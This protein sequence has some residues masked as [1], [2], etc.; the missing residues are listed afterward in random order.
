[1]AGGVVA[2]AYNIADKTDGEVPTGTRFQASQFENIDRDIPFIPIRQSVRITNTTEVMQRG[3][4]VRFLR[5]NNL[6]TKFRSYVDAAQTDATHPNR[7]K[8][9]DV[10]E[11]MEMI[12][13]SPKTRSIGAADLGRQRQW[14]AYITDLVGSSTFVNR[15][16]PAAFWDGGAAND[17]TFTYQTAAAQPMSVLLFLIETHSV[18][19]NAFEIAVMSQRL[20][21]FPYGSLM[22]SFSFDVPHMSH[23]AAHKLKAHEEKHE[24]NAGAI[25]EGGAVTAATGLLANKFASSIPTT[26][27]F[28]SSLLEAATTGMEM[29]AMA[30]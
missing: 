30:A 29:M 21:R 23:E 3:G 17:G 20:Y 12:R 8:V 1:V 13:D 28:T 14:N 6:S 19:S 7:P 26:A 4:I 2:N 24:H 16:L 27:E 10:K 22:A 9:S 11:L 15:D 18:E 5:V 25:V